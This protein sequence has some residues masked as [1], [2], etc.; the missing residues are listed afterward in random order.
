[1]T[2]PIFRT[3]RSAGDEMKAAV[4]LPATERRGSIDD[5]IPSTLTSAGGFFLLRADGGVH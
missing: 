2:M 3:G 1:V 4:G 5:G